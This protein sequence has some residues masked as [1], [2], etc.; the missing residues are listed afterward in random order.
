LGVGCKRRVDRN[1]GGSGDVITLAS[2][3]GGGY[4]APMR[5]GDRRGSRKGRE[6]R[7]TPDGRAG[8]GRV[9]SMGR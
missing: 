1:E 4:S 6:G 2:W 8:E 5:N 9:P 3:D 7:G